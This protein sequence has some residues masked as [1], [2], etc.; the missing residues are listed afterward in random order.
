MQVRE[1]ILRKPDW[2]KIKISNNNEFSSVS[3]ILNENEVHT[4]CVSGNCP[5]K[6]ECWARGTATIMIMGDICT[7]HCKFCNVAA[8]HPLPLDQNEPIKVARSIK[9]MKLKHCVLT[10]VDR[11]DLPDYGANHWAKTIQEVKEINPGITIES[12]IPDF[13]GDFGKL[14]IVLSAGSDVVSHNLETVRSITPKLRSKAQYDR[15]LMILEHISK[16]GHTAKSGIMVGVGET[17]EEVFELMDDLLKVNCKILTIGQY[18]QPT[19]K[20]YP[21][22]EYVHPDIF[23]EYKEVGLQKGF[24]FIESGPMVRSSYFAERH[25]NVEL[26]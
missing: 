23:A 25:I 8:G 18:L 7:R 12:L 4:I 22:M 17:K 2:L 16:M 5:N 11:D 14:D 19:L 20:H 13:N 1:K 10:S 21:V 6:H 9:L 26:K 15:S 24:R 3:E